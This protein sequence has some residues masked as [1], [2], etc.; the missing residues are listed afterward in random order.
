MITR[1][2]TMLL[3]AFVAFVALDAIYSCVFSMCILASIGESV[4]PSLGHALIESRKIVKNNFGFHFQG[5]LKVQMAQ[6][7]MNFCRT[8]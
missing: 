1:V 4:P 2:I 5:A 3:V 6:I 8:I 7:H